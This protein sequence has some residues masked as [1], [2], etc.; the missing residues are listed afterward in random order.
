M[1]DFAALKQLHYQLAGLAWDSLSNP[2]FEVEDREQAEQRVRASALDK[3]TEQARALADRQ[4][5]ELG[6]IWGII[7]EPLH[8]LAGRSPGVVGDPMMNVSAL[9][10]SADESRFALP[11]EPRPVVFQARVGVVYTLQAEPR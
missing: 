7:Y 5:A 6:R 10:M 4:G 9:R 2:R 8:D 11:A 3:A 1:D